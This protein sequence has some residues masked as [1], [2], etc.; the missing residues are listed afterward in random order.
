MTYIRKKK[1]KGDRR[2]RRERKHGRNKEVY[3]WEIFVQ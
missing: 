2:R 1:G 3:R